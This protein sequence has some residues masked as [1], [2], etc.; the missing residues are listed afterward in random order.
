M[1]VEGTKM[2]SNMRADI[3]YAAGHQV[4]RKFFHKMSRMFT[5]AFNEVAWLQVHQML[6][7]EV[8]RLF[9]VWA[10]KQGMN[11]AATN[12]NLRR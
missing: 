2:T 11:L 6:S 9:Q 12:K 8:P 4:A 7:N 5:D 3:R 1:F 10:C